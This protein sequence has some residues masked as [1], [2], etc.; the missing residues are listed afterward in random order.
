MQ[1]VLQGLSQG[2]P[3]TLLAHQNGL[4]RSTVHA[5]KAEDEEFAQ[6]YVYARALGFD[7]I[8]HECLQIADDTSEDLMADAHGVLRPNHA[9]VLRARLAIDVR[10]RLLAKWSSGGTC[11]QRSVKVDA[12]V[13][14]K[15]APARHRPA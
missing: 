5:W 4:H 8:A 7:R 11:R 14:A 12:N 1:R 6:A 2:V 3:L 15:E 10:L 13:V 9:A